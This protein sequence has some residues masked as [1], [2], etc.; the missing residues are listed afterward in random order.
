MCSLALKQRSFVDPPTEFGAEPNELADQLTLGMPGALPVLNQK[1]VDYAIMLGLATNC[2]IR[3]HN[4]FARKHYFY[5]DLP[6]GY[7]ISQFEQPICEHGKI[8]IEVDDKP[9]EIGITRIHMEEDAGKNIHDTRTQ[10]S[11]MDYNRAGVPLLEIVSE[12]DIRSAAQATAYMQTIRQLVRFIGVSDGNME[13]GSLR[14]DV[15]ISLMPKGSDQFGTRA[16]I[17]NLNSFKFV[18][19]AIEY[20]IERQSELLNQGEK[21]VQE[22]RLFDSE[23][24]VTRSMRTKE[25]SAD[26]RYFPDPDLPPL[27]IDQAWM[28]RIAGILPMLPKEAAQRLIDEH[29]LSAYDAKVLVAER[30]IIDFFNEAIQSGAKPK[31][32]ANWITTELFGALNKN[33]LNFSESLVKAAD[34]G[35]LVVLIETGKISG[36]IA[37]RVFELMFESGE[38]PDIIVEREGLSQISDP[39]TIRGFVGKVLD[40]NLD[41]L[42]QYLG[43]KKQLRGF[44]VGQSL[45]ESSGKANPQ[46]LNKILDQ[47]LKKRESS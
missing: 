11:L 37:K 10:T 15:N 46:V 45:K 34:L 2:K 20:E 9:I 42:N 3:R 22:T 16:E 33:Q 41:Q 35:Q 27:E 25:E 23:K 21:I 40:S 13:Q 39:E 6:K 29:A 32:V 31:A 30:E 1:V 43:G 17:K 26:Y 38:S 36:K 7:Q 12:P 28:D 4:R 44:F 47:E 14:C 8:E 24:G 19:K 5:P 18:E